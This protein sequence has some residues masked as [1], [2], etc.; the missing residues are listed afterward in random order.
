[1]MDEFGHEQ[2]VRVTEQLKQAAIQNAQAGVNARASRAVECEDCG[3]R[4]DAARLKA[5]PST[6]RCTACQTKWE[7]S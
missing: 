5:V 4:L 3:E 7:R 2:S 1:M 6:V